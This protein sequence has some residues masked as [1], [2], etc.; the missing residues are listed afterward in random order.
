MWNTVHVFLHQTQT[1][2]LLID[3]SSILTRSKRNHFHFL[4]R[5]YTSI[6]DQFNFDAN[7]Q[8]SSNMP[9]M[10]LVFLFNIL[11]QCNLQHKLVIVPLIY[12][13][14]FFLIHFLAINKKSWL[15]VQNLIIALSRV[16]ISFEAFRLT[17]IKKDRQSGG[18]KKGRVFIEGAEL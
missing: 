16:F 1:N 6:L 7:F 12:L 18:H 3:F 11:K 4:I 14:F 15:V 17:L 8:K 5:S 9:K 13:L 2:K 10:I